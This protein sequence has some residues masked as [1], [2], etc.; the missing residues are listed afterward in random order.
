MKESFDQD[1]VMARRF[2]QFPFASDLAHPATLLTTLRK[3]TIHHRSYPLT[4]LGSRISQVEGVDSTAGNT[5][6]GTRS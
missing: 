1:V 4:I 2:G 6:R 5:E 3:W